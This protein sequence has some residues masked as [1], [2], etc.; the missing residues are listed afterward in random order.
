MSKLTLQ[1][2]FYPIVSW[3]YTF[4]SWFYPIVFLV[5]QC[6]VLVLLYCVLVHTLLCPGFTLLCPGSTLLFPGYTLLCPGSLHYSVCTAVNKICLQAEFSIKLETILTADR[7]INQV[8]VPTL[9]TVYIQSTKE[10]RK[11]LIH[12]RPCSAILCYSSATL[13]FNRWL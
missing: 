5:L 2:E 13:L 9:G 10:K 11:P 6:C 4:V 8:P 7:D 1:V 12:F 3:F